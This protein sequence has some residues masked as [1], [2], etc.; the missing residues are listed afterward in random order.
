MS[1]EKLP[2]P[3]FKLL[4]ADVGSEFQ[5]KMN[6]AML[7]VR[8]AIIA[9]NAQ[10]DANETST[11]RV[12]QMNSLIQQVELDSNNAIVQ[13]LT[14]TDAEVEVEFG[15]QTQLVVP[16][17]YLREQVEGSIDSAFAYAQAS[18][19]SAAASEALAKF[20]PTTEAGLA[21]VAEG[22][23]FQVPA[24][25]ETE[26][27]IVYKKVAGVAV[28]IKRSPSGKAV[29]DLNDRVLANEQT[30]EPVAEAI[31][32]QFSVSPEY[33]WGVIDALNRIGLG[34]RR[35]GTLYA[36][37][38]DLKFEGAA[39]ESG[40]ETIDPDML[41]IVDSNGRIALRITKDGSIVG[42]V[43]KPEKDEEIVQSRGSRE[44]LA[45]RLGMFLNEY[46]LPKTHVYG[47]WYLRET[48]QRLRKRYLAE[49][50]KLVVAS[51][52]DSWTHNAGRWCGPAS[53]S[54]KTEFGD[55]GAGYVS[56]ARNGTNLPNGNVL[57]TAAVTYTGVWNT[58]AY[59]SNYSPDL[60][61]ATSSTPGDRLSYTVAP[62]PSSVRLFAK[63]GAG[64]VQYRFGGAAWT[65]L[66]LS[67]LPAELQVVDLPS[68]TAGVLDI[69]VES[70]S[71]ILFGID[72]QKAT[73]GIRWHKLGATGSRAQNWTNADEIQWKKGIQALSPNL[74]IIL[75]GTNDQASYN[76]V[77]YKLHMQ[78][79]I[80]R[81]RSALPF[82]DIL[83]IAPAENGRANTHPMSGYAMALYEL[84]V[85][86][87]S[88]Y[89]DLQYVFGDSFS[90]YSSTSLRPWFNSDLIH[91]DPLTGGRAIVDAV[92]RLL[93]N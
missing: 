10:I 31:L 83:L 34:L 80:D 27:T 59:Y 50:A 46:G 5:Q 69:E 61:A 7:G 85:T 29:A 14:S 4:T 91:P 49:P 77:T 68:P 23:F 65:S 41:C 38:K 64:I 70:G 57:S 88:A 86:N 6:A 36:K 78:T 21:A 62:E 3:E 39:F 72:V 42:K 93:K 82:A 60:G 11:D 35:D 28:E 32:P 37:F 84:A 92:V 9:F 44:N 54:L 19:A 25:A 53:A 2:V 73:D 43:G 8:N 13:V 1:I 58:S 79:L 33:V 81:V 89:L 45:D 52:G 17:G 18:A 63:G 12:S 16:Y 22:L 24:S 76:A 48:R 55:A 30:I 74:V 71:P 51:I 90:D 87:K 26:F 66:D 20:Y 15:G 47:E 75:H 40:F 56:F 67:V